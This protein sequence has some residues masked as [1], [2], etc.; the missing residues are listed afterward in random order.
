MKST[1]TWQTLVRLRTDS[2]RTPHSP[3]GVHKDIWG[4]VKYC[5][6]ATSFWPLRKANGK[7]TGS[8]C[9]AVPKMVKTT[10]YITLA[11]MF[12]NDVVILTPMMFDTLGFLI[13]IYSCAIIGV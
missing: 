2:T 10:S 6:G 13:G 1:Q 12:S 3:H 7:Q 8:V 5:V 4:S 11:S 9:H